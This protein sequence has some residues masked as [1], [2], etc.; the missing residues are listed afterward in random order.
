MPEYRPNDA[1]PADGRSGQDWARELERG[2]L[3]SLKSQPKT[4]GPVPPAVTNG[5]G[6]ERV[7]ARELTHQRQAAMALEGPEGL[8]GPG[9]AGGGAAAAKAALNPGAIASQLPA[10]LKK[11]KEFG[12]TI[13]YRQSMWN[14]N[15][16]VEAHWGIASL[17]VL[18]AIMGHKLKNDGM[19][20]KTASELNDFM[21]KSGMSEIP[22]PYVKLVSRYLK[23]FTAINTGEWLRLMANFLMVYGT[24]LIGATLIVMVC[25][26]YDS[27]VSCGLQ[28]VK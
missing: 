4:A 24:L 20:K 5:T 26:C 9:A 18:P 12:Q 7:W 27:P 22:N 10:M 16:R 25:Y 6:D 15:D 3:S 28:L 21:K 8:A 23:H 14:I 19:L 17:F 11:A 13:S 1:G 2:R